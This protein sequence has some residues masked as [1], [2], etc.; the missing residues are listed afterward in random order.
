M[1]IGVGIGIA[2]FLAAG[3]SLTV[4]LFEPSAIDLSTAAIA[5]AG[6]LALALTVNAIQSLGLARVPLSQC[7]R[8]Q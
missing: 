4:L 5:G 3:R 2:G 6:T 8:G 1:L 7:W